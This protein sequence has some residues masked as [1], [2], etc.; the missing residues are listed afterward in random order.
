MKNFQL[1][2]FETLGLQQLQIR[3]AKLGVWIICCARRDFVKQKILSS[4]HFLNQMS[5][6]PQVAL[7]LHLSSLL[8]RLTLAQTRN[9]GTPLMTS[10]SPLTFSSHCPLCLKQLSLEPKPVSTLET[11]LLKLSFLKSVSFPLSP[12]WNYFYLLPLFT[13]SVL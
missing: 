2:V 12:S 9:L 5:D 6:P 8:K 7:P 3:I 4:Q 10:P 11:L 1:R 13:E